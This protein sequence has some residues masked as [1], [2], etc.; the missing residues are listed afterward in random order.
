MALSAFCGGSSTPTD[1]IVDLV[2]LDE[3][4]LQEGNGRYAASIHTGGE[5]CYDM[6]LVFWSLFLSGVPMIM[7]LQ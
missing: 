3:E 6:M 2:H 1:I 4:K 5:A 7:V